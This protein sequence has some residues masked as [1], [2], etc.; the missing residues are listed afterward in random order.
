MDNLVQPNQD[1]IEIDENKDYLAELVGDDKKFKTPQELAKGKWHSDRM[2]ELQNKRLD[3]MREDYLRIRD[4]NQAKAKLEEYIDRITKQQTIS[5]TPPQVN[6]DEPKQ[7]D[8]DQIKS[9]VSSQIQEETTKRQQD[10]NFSKVQNKLVERYGKNYSNSLSEQIQN[11]G[12]TD[13]QITDLAKSAPDAA[14]RL[15]GLDSQPQRD[16]FQSPPRNQQRSDTFAP[17]TQKRTWQ[18]YQ[19]MRKANPDLYNDRKIAN[20][21]IQ[22]AVELGDEFNDGDFYV[23]GLHEK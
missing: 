23:R 19:E 20:Q 1:Q 11:L 17:K 7:I 12:M 13:R 3:D 21:M 5:N 18:Y 9:L 15:L 14:M 22:D 2:I 6:M 16:G 8:M 4:E 10:S